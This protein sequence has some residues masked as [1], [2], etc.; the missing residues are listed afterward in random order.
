[1]WIPKHF[2]SI[3]KFMFSLIWPLQLLKQHSEYLVLQLREVLLSNSL[4]NFKWIYQCSNS[5]PS[6]VKIKRSLIFKGFVGFIREVEW[7]AYGFSPTAFTISVN[8]SYLWETKCSTQYCGGKLVCRAHKHRNN[9]KDDALAFIQL[10]L[11]CELLYFLAFC[12]QF[13]LVKT[14]QAHFHPSIQY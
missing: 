10:W 12:H 11:Q 14:Q 6:G 8:I 7:L 4:D 13:H 3:L 1:M 2:F 5:G 9:K